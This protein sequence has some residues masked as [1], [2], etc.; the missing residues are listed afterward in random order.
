MEIVQD[1]KERAKRKVLR[2]LRQGEV[3]YDPKL[4]KLIYTDTKE[5]FQFDKDSDGDDSDW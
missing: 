5:E 1:L 4:D 3:D 2:Q